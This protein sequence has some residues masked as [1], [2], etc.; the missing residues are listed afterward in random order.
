MSKRKVFCVIFS[1]CWIIGLSNGVTADSAPMD[2]EMA[3]QKAQEEMDL[4]EWNNQIR[5]EKFDIVL[6]QAMR[7]NNVD[8]WIHVMRVAIRDPFG[9]QD[10]G[11]TSGLFV[12][13]DRGGNRI[14]RAVL[15]RRWGETQRERGKPSRLIEESGVYDIIADPVFVVEPVASQMTEYDYRFKGLREFVEAR[16][17]KRI[18]VNYR[19][20]LGTWATSSRTN[21]GIS[22]I[23]YLLLTKELGEK[24]SK[25]LVS[26]EY[27]IMDYN[28]TP[29]PSEIELL[30]KMREEELEIVKKAF[31][32][33][34]PGVT[35][36]SEVGDTGNWEADVV[37]FR[38]ME[39]GQSQR[40]RSKGWENTV[41]QGGDIVA[42]P[43]QGIF[44]YV[45]REG[46]TEPPP[47]I[48]KLWADYLKID[49]ILAETIKAGLTGREIMES[50]KKRFKE[51]GIIV[52]DPQLHMFQPKNNFPV[53]S[54]GYDP[55]KTHL[56]IDCHGKGK[57]AR[58]RKF[59]IYMGPRI[60]SYGPEWTWDV[61][62]KPNHHFVLE[63]FFY[64]PSPAPEGKDQYLFWWNHEQAIAT[65][66]GVEYLSPPQKELYLIK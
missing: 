57:G 19:E 47:E 50:Y 29:V 5:K 59:D 45:L 10:L 23:D 15:G 35:K 12:F 7:K 61:P 34:K 51:A 28:T 41:V 27:V 1:L 3:S 18:A 37:V 17:P 52:R 60:G 32:N 22:H 63:Y 26:S 62:L 40:G 6:P 16:D 54:E 39:T 38:R 33:I 43:S 58:E 14:E 48:K 56:S 42:A 31:A 65:P 8:M 21:D 55:D 4:K 36:T 20:N 49:K 25:R 11:S 30:K 64:M 24:Y 9:A 46:E 66:D 2:A 13:T 44:A 53:Y